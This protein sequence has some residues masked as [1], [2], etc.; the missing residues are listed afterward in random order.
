M[1]KMMNSSNKSGITARLISLIIIISLVLVTGSLFVLRTASYAEADVSPVLKVSQSIN[2]ESGAKTKNNTFT[3]SLSASDATCPL[4]E[5]SKG[6]DWE[7]ELTD[8]DH[9]NVHFLAGSDAAPSSGIPIRFTGTGTY[10]YKLTQKTKGGRDNVICDETVYDIF[11]KVS[12]GNGLTVEAVWVQRDTGEKPEVITFKNTV[13]ACTVIGDPPVK[14]VKRIE[15]D[16]PAKKDKFVFAMRPDRR[17]FPLPHGAQ[18]EYETAIYGEGQIEIGEIEFDAPGT[19]SYRVYEKAASSPYYIMDRTEYR[20][21]Y[22]VNMED[23]G[24]LS[25][26]RQIISEDNTREECVFT[27]RYNAPNVDPRDESVKKDKPGGERGVDTGD[28][29]PLG[30]FVMLLIGASGAIILLRLL[31]RTN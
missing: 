25:C 29:T 19:Y 21:I 23:D 14:V 28:N 12:G 7:F 3:Y 31:F 24:T 9:I 10:R 22:R 17:D 30:L 13:K 5:G 27:N 18:G 6:T 4:P 2:V 20:V 26:V 8:E 1:N 11:V 16:T 15:G